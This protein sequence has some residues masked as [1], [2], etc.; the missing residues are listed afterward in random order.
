MTKLVT[1]FGGSGFVGRYIARRMAKEG[2]RVR[3]AVRNYN[4]LMVLWVR[5]NLCFAIFVMMR[6]SR[7]SWVALMRL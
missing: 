3:V 7:P 2:W 5:S 6:L 4:A 1:I